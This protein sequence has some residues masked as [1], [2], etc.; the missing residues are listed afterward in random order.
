M[1]ARISLL[2]FVLFFSSFGIQDLFAQF[3][4]QRSVE[5]RTPW[6]PDGRDPDRQA[7]REGFFR[8][9]PSLVS[10]ASE[11]GGQASLRTRDERVDVGSSQKMNDL[12]WGEYRATWG[13]G[14]DASFVW[15]VAGG[16]IGSGFGVRRSGFHEGLDI[17]GREGQRIMSIGHGRVVFAGRLDGYGNT[18][19][20]YHGAGVTSVYAHNREN[21]AQ[22]G[23][24]VEKGQTIATLGQTGRA[25]GPHLHLEIRRDGK[26]E[27][28]LRYRFDRS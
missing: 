17:R 10:G 15:P 2:S 7:R 5:R 13:G 4:W 19:V 6:S 8:Q 16:E 24:L 22:V 26:P 21:L 1:T 14:F 28:P 27:N 11:S 18:V 25:T 9:L 12:P 23:Q 3:P 20:V